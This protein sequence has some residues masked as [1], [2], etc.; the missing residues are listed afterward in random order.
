MRAE[1]RVTRDLSREGRFPPRVATGAALV[2]TAGEIGAGTWT[3]LLVTGAM[4]GTLLAIMIAGGKGGVP[5]GT[6][7]LLGAGLG[8]GV[9]YL[10][11][12]QLSENA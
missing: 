7:L 1:G 9:G 6:G 3:F 2:R 5:S 12:R 4:G 11:G 10:F 8:A